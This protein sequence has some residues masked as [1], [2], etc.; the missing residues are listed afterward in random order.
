MTQRRRAKPAPRE[1][2]A[3]VARRHRGPLYGL[4]LANAVSPLGN[5]A[6]LSYGLVIDAMCCP[7]QKWFAHATRACRR[8]APFFRQNTKPATSAA[9]AS[10]RTRAISRR[11]NPSE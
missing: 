5:V 3:R 11:E 9:P 6:M 2:V 4:I 1:P 8:Q 10:R 7:A